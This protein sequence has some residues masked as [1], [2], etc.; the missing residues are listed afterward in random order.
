M[1]ITVQNLILDRDMVLKP[2]QQVW[3]WEVPV[4]QEKYGESKVRLTD[5]AE[6]ERKGLPNPGEEYVRLVQAHGIDGGSGGTNL[7][8]AELAYGRGKPAVTA[9][10][11]VIKGSAKK[12]STA[13][14]P[15]PAPKAEEG[16]DDPLGM[17]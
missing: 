13:K 7:P 15:A 2:H 4:L 12:P 14:K 8:Y 5:T 16:E 11:K 9:L 1:K 6:V 3:P 10:G 17:G